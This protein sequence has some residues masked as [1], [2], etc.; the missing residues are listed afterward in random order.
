MS[1][2]QILNLGTVRALIVSASP[3]VNRTLI[4]YDTTTHIHKYFNIDTEQWVTLGSGGVIL[5]PEPILIEYEDLTSG[6]IYENSAW[7]KY[8]PFMMVDNTIW[9]KK[10]ID[11]TNSPTGGFTLSPSG[12]VPQLYPGQVIWV[13]NFKK[14]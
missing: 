12:A 5:P 13:V 1:S 11:F 6:T 8:Y 10:D 14:V 4:W 9:L 2:L 7:E 3:P